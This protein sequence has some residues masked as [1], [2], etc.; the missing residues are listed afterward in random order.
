MVIG[1]VNWS[2]LNIY[3]KDIIFHFDFGSFFW[4]L[5]YS[6]YVTCVNVDVLFI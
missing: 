6:I 5:V 3:P 1:E 4:F 2:G